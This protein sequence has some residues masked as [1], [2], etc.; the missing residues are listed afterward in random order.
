[1]GRM[2]PAVLVYNVLPSLDSNGRLCTQGSRFS[3][4]AIYPEHRRYINSEAKPPRMY[5]CPR[6]RFN[7]LCTRQF[8]RQ[9]GNFVD[10]GGLFLRLDF[11]R[12]NEVLILLVEFFE[13]LLDSSDIVD[14]ALPE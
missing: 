3:R 8:S 5:A 7:P 12:N 9:L 11:K 4:H 14:F 6:S 2:A 13:L 10:E 1:M